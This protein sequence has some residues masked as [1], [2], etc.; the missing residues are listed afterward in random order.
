MSSL[1]PVARMTI[2]ELAREAGITTRNVRAYQDRGL[3]PPP[4]KLGRTGY[5]GEIHLARLRVIGR[6]LGR[7]YSLQSIGDLFSTWEEGRSLSD[8]LGFE[9]AMVGGQRRPAKV[10]VAGDDLAE[11]FGGFDADLVTR[12]AGLGVLEEADDG[13]LVPDIQLIEIG[14][15]LVAA[16]YDLG[17][18]LHETELLQREARVIA[19][20][21]LDLWER[22][23][24]APYVAEGSPPGRLPE[25]TAAMDSLREIP[26]L[27]ASTM[28]GIAMREQSDARVARL[29][30][31]GHAR[32]TSGGTAKRAPT[33]GTKPSAKRAA[34]PA[35]R[36]AT[37]K[38]A[39]KAAKPAATSAARKAAGKTL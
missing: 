16:G 6:L 13:F 31:A 26:A 33:R 23:V 9:E 21:W 32:A 30:E 20:R 14:R 29:I 36:N 4:Q 25:I 15:A 8:V 12:A 18:L 2:D 27:T 1:G 22:A 24:W 35:A 3:L 38:A 17:A 19:K 7:G 28:I 34:E 5:Y 37:K 39:K 10:Q 11:W